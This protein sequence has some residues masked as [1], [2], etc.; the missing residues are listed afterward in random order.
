M[1]LSAKNLH[2]LVTD[3]WLSNPKNVL[4]VRLDAP[5]WR[6]AGVAA[7]TTPSAM[8]SWGVEAVASWL[9][10]LGMAGPAAHFRAQGVNGKDLMGYESEADLMRDLATTPFVARKVLMLREQHAAAQV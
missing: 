1:D 7:V 3:H 9:E 5:A 2:M 10:S 8:A 4:V 6:T